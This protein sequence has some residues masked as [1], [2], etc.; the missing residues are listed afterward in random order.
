M[1]DAKKMELIE[2][3]LDAEEGTLTPETELDSIEEWGSLA[4][5]SLVVMID[6]ECGKTITNDVIK[7]L[8]T[9]R[10]I[11]DVMD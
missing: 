2:E 9:V 11:M 10:D 6:E 5:L 1:T 3:L 4:K 8:K 7:S